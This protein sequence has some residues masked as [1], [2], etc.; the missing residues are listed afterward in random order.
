M[1]GVFPKARSLFGGAGSGFGFAQGS[2][3]S[4]AGDEEDEEGDSGNDD[5]DIVGLA[6]DGDEVGDEVERGDEVGDQRD[7]DEPRGAANG[8][9]PEEGAAGAEPARGREGEEAAATV[10]GAQSEVR[11]RS[12]KEERDGDGSGP[13]VP[14]HEEIVTVARPGVDGRR[15]GWRR[16]AATIGGLSGGAGT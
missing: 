10:G 12:G 13:A 3:E 16:L 2:F 11:Q 9:V 7:E 1:R 4:V 8:T 15:C 5:R 6:E 14:G